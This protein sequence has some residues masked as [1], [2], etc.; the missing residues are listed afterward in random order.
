M[1][2]IPINVCFPVEFDIFF[3]VKYFLNQ[4]FIFGIYFLSVTLYLRHDW[5]SY[6][7]VVC[8]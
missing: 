6:Y 5:S 1:T 8:D 4:E 3:Y 2:N 7:E